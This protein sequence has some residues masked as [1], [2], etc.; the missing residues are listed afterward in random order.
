MQHGTALRA[1]VELRP[2]AWEDQSFLRFLTSAATRPE[3][4]TSAITLGM[5]ISWLKVSV[6]YQTRSLESREPR[7]MKA[8]ASTE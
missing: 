5:T 8:M 1:A 4:A 7:K 2:V 3:R 6:S